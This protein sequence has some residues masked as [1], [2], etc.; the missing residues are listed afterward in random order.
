[1]TFE[2]PTGDIKNMASET[3][4]Y[5][6]L[7]WKYCMLDNG[8][9]GVGVDIASQGDSVVP[10]AMGFDLP[11]DEFNFYCSNQPA[12]GPIQLR[13]HA[14]KLPFETESL[15]FFYSSHLL[16]DYLDWTPVLQ[17]WTRVLRPNGYMIILVPDKELWAKAIA[18]G[19]N[20][21]CSHKHESHAGELTTYA[22]ALRLKVIEDRLTNQF[23]GDYSVLFVG[24]R[25]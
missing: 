3:S 21:N 17:E 11:V 19:Q 14:D 13:G 9:P 25:Y 4:K 8:Y 22:E 23:E 1:M 5:R 24:R 7:T 10:W 16:E 6:H 20:P 18:N 2:K 12:K 15:D